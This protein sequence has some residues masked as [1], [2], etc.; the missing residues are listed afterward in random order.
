ML[1]CYYITLIIGIF[2]GGTQEACFYQGKEG[3]GILNIIAHFLMF[4]G[5]NPYWINSIL[6]IEWYLFALVIIYLLMPILVKHIN[7]IEKSIVALCLSIP[8]IIM[9]NILL[10]ELQLIKEQEIWYNF[11]GGLSI[12]FHIPAVFSGCLVFNLVKGSIRNQSK[13]KCILSN[14]ILIGAICLL[15]LLICSSIKYDAI[16]WQI[17]LGTVLLSQF[18]WENPL[19]SNI[20]FVKLGKRSYEIYLFH[21]L[22]I[23]LIVRIP[24]IIS[25]TMLDWFLKLIILISTSWLLG[26]MYHFMQVKFSRLEGC[27]LKL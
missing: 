2:I 27:F 12:L 25:N 23:Q 20:F 14:S 26:E 4:Y 19:I 3:I 11:I 18:I 5:L 10:K 22:L 1:P 16:F 17:L 13:K 24:V 15:I 21:I 7:T 8:T 6:G 9:L